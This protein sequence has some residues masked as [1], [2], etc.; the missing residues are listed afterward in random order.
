MHKKRANN[1]TPKFGNQVRVHSKNWL[2]GM[3]R[4]YSRAPKI[5]KN[6]KELQRPIRDSK[7]LLRTLRISKQLLEHIVSCDCRAF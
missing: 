5:I 1:Q 4:I 3:L 2:L 6:S 7:D